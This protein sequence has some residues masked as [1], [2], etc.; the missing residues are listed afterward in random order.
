VIQSASL[1]SQRTVL[2]TVSTIAALARDAGIGMPA[3]TVV[4]EVVRL[5]ERLR[6]YDRQPLFGKRVLLP[7][8]EGQAREMA[9]L[10]RDMGAEPV[11]VPAIRIVAPEDRAP[12]RSAVQRLSDYDFVVLTSQNGVDALFAE[13]EAQGGDARKLGRAKIAVIGPATAE[14]LRAHGI[15]ADLMPEAHVGEA[16]AEAIVQA[17]GATLQGKRVLIPRAAVARDALPERLRRAG[18]SVD[19]IAA[20]RTLPPSDE[21]AARLRSLLAEPSAEG[22]IDIV[23]FTSSSTVDHIAAALGAK[24]A[25]LL[26]ARTVAVIGPITRE[27]ALR[28]GLRVDVEAEPYTARGLI[29]ALEAHFETKPTETP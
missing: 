11:L 13:I 17:H 29:T 6:W 1:P 19:V 18:A 3:L 12:L 7:R 4:G 28:H 25:E 14:R 27:T 2:G 9:Q 21:D 5:R 15:V 20:Y 26:A 23:T 24:A 22:A 8:A 10:L 16:V